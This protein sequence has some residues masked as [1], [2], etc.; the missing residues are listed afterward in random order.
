MVEY[1]SLQIWK[2]AILLYIDEVPR[3]VYVDERW[4]TGRG[5][6]DEYSTVCLL[7]IANVKGKYNLQS[8]KVAVCLLCH[9]ILEGLA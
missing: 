2:Y 3:R 5:G 8:R 1:G 9:L 6:G 4:G 7:Y